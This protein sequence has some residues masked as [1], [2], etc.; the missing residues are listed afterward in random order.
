[1]SIAEERDFASGIRFGGL[2]VA[3][4][5]VFGRAVAGDWHSEAGTVRGFFHDGWPGAVIWLIALII[6]RFARPNRRR[7]FPS[8]P[9]FGLI[10]AILYLVLAAAWL[11]HLGAWEGMSK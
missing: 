4:G 2:L 9:I 11:W 6:E 8:W 5:L 3:M 1:M 7:P 10:P